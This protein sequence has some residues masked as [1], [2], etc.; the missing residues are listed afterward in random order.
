MSDDL[1]LQNEYPENIRGE[2]Q[3]KVQHEQYQ[4]QIM[5][6]MQQASSQQF[7]TLEEHKQ[8]Q[9]FALSPE[10]ETEERDCLHM[11]S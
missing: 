3:A 10:F 8:R 6:D 5:G 11:L 7:V 2:F 4:A 9:S 1:A